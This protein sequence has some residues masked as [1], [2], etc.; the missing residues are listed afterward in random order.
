MSTRVRFSA[1]MESGVMMSVRTP[2]VVVSL[3]V[4]GY[5]LRASA[6]S[7]ARYASV[8]ARRS[9]R[10]SGPGVLCVSEFSQV[11]A[12][13]LMVL[14]IG[15]TRVMWAVPSASNVAESFA[16]AEGD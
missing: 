5:N 4:T 7:C 8:R 10:L 12:S 13:G 16:G 2:A 9:A 15:T 1:G 6:V 14:G 11:C 3:M